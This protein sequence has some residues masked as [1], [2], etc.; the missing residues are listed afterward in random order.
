[1]TPPSKLSDEEIAELDTVMQDEDTGRPVRI[2][3]TD[4]GL[5][6]HSGW[7]RF[8][9]AVSESHVMDVETVGLW[10]G[11]NARVVMIAHSRDS[12]N[13]NWNVSM[14][15]YKPCILKKEWLG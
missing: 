12:V 6:Y 1:M 5:A 8:H 11:E 13:E 10:M 4:S 2:V 7:E 15:I 9:D 3:W 14:A